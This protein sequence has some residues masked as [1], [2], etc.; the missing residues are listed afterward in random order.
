MLMMLIGKSKE[1]YDKAFEAYKDVEHRHGV[2]YISVSQ[3]YSIYNGA[4]FVLFVS[5]HASKF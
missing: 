2:E 1:V 4:V 3:K 5:L